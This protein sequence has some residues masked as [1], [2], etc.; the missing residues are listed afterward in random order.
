MLLALGIPAF[1]ALASPDSG[2]TAEK[3]A[4]KAA[5]PNRMVCK[6]M[7]EAGSRLTTKRVCKT[8]AEWA[9]ENAANRRDLERIQ[10]GR[11]TSY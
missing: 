10:T 8:A 3:G 6:R 1:P 5:D 4:D 2:T 11:T 9:A 7:E